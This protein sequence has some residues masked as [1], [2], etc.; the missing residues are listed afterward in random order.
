[1]EDLSLSFVLFS[2]SLVSLPLDFR[3]VRHHLGWIFTSILFS[4][5]LSLPKSKNSP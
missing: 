1:L 2:L 3:R 4:W 5:I